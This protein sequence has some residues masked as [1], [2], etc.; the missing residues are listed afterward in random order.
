MANT[1]KKVL[2]TIQVKVHGITDAIE[3]SDTTSAP[4]AT[5]ALAEFEKGYKMHLKGASSE[6]IVPYHAVEAVTV[7]SALSDSITK[8]DPYC[9]DEDAS[10]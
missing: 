5:N 2:K 1:Y 3:V 9:A 6:T 8:A 7:T 10:E 4:N